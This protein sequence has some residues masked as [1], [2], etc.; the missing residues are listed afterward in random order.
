MVKALLKVGVLRGKWRG[1]GQHI[2]RAKPQRYPQLGEHMQRVSELAYVQQRTPQQLMS[3]N[4]SLR[5][6]IDASSRTVS[7]ENI[8]CAPRSY[9]A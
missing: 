2:V 7:Q 6:T 8:F 1:R 9:T 4:I 5:I 3:A